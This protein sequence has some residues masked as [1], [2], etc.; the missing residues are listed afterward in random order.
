MAFTEDT[1]RY[2]TFKLGDLVHYHDK[3]VIPP[4]AINWK[5]NETDTSDSLAIIIELDTAQWDMQ[6]YGRYQL[7]KIKH[8]KSGIIRT[9]SSHNLT[10]AYISE[11]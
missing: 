2:R 5:F 11:E 1:N 8:V 4:D 10:K 9:C 6:P 3:F 7:F